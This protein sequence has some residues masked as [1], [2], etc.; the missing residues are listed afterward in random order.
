[1]SRAARWSADPVATRSGAGWEGVVRRSPKLRSL[2]A[3]L[4]A[5]YIRLCAR[6]IRWQVEG[7]DGFEAMMRDD[8]R[9]TIAS[10]WHGRLFITPT[11]V[12]DDRH[13]LTLISNNRDGTLVA[14]VVARF[15]IGAI[16]GST[17][18][19]A[20]RRS[21]GGATAFRQAAGALR[22]DRAKLL[23]TPDGPRGPRLSAHPGVAQL[24]IATGCPVVPAAFSVTR[25]WQLGTWD[26]FLLPMPFGRGAVVFGAPLW[27][28]SE[29]GASRVEAFR[30]EIEVR[31]TEAMY[32]ADALCG[33]AAV[34]ADPT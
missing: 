32:R 28:P 15:G 2:A 30:L 18:D 5:G 7:G 16:R 4:C 9:G 3:W 24:A 6:M 17:D 29:G 14:E 13:C 20:K 33:R 8:E 23:V 31:T 27:P 10:V 19:P 1:M 25:G 11:W 22:R 12:R 21:K 34:A 26:R